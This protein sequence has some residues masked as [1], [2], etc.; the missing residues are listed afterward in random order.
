[1]SFEPANT[2]RSRTFIGLLIAQFLAAFNDQAIHAAAMFFAIK[3]GTLDTG[4]AISLMPIL[5][6]APWVLFC[7]VAGYFADRFSKRSSLVFWKLAEILIT[8]LALVGFYL[9]SEVGNPLGPYLVL[10][11]VFLMG[12]HST[13]F[14]PAKYGAMPEIMQPQLLSRGNG[15]LESLS[16]SAVILGTVT[17]GVL[18]TVWDGDE[19]KIG[20][21]LVCLA[22]IGAL[23]SLLIKKMPAANPQRRFPLSIFGPLVGNLRIMIRSRPLNLAVLGIAFFTFVVVF[24]RASVYMHGESQVPQWTERKTSIIVG[25]TAF[26]IGLGSPL[27]GYFSGRKVELGLIPLGG[28]G[29]IVCTLLAAVALDWLPGLVA[30]IIL[31]GFCTGFYLVPMFSLLQHRAPKTSKGDLVATSNFLS[32]TGAILASGVF[33]GLEK[34]AEKFSLA[35]PVPQTPLVTGTL[36]D[37][38]IQDGRPHSFQVLGQKDLFD[39]KAIARLKL[40]KPVQQKWAATGTLRNLEVDKEGRPAAFEILGEDEELYDFPRREQ[41]KIF[42]TKK[43]LI[44]RLE[45]GDPVDVSTYQIGS[46]TFIALRTASDDPLG[47]VYSFPHRENQEIHMKKIGWILRLDDGDAV[48]VATFQIGPET[49]ISVRQA[50]NEPLGFAYDKSEVGRYL[51][52]GA[53]LITLITLLLLRIRLPDLVLRS[54]IWLH[55]LGRFQIRVEGMNNLPSEGPLILVT[56]CRKVESILLVLAV[57]DRYTRFIY[58]DKAGEAALPATLRLFLWQ[59]RLAVL[60]PGSTTPEARAKALA[61]AE[62]TLARGNIVGLAAGNDLGPDHEN[63]LLEDLEELAKPTSA[64]LL[65]VF[66]DG[67]HPPPH[68]HSMIHH[69]NQVRVVIGRTIPADTPPETLRSQL[70]RLAEGLA[71]PTS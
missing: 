43:G 42:L 41:Q 21:L 53:A 16:F 15:L 8:L 18:S 49:F 35:K 11:T 33:L 13:F 1:M 12:L 48:D 7:T 29:M 31:I 25:M 58:E 6:Y 63:G 70:T 44:Q 52:V 27:A 45:D 47:Y 2:L 24:M 28:L 38:N 57:T 36:V 66:C 64:S 50:S 67:D 61:L 17:G 22:L 59:S 32:V 3:Q 10:A 4:Q 69:A 34:V 39:E 68:P 56:N 71:E 23:A 40:A 46:E 55:S 14:V 9:G 19:Y 54:F 20:L 30:S 51:F 5:F 62:R 60:G 26:G 37:L 65:P